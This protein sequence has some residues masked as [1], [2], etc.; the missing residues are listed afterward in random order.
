MQNQSSR[1]VLMN[2]LSAQGNC[3]SADALK[4]KFWL[5]PAFGLESKGEFRA[6]RSSTRFHLDWPAYAAGS[7]QGTRPL[8]P[9]CRLRA[10]IRFR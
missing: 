1:L 10:G 7:R 8:D 2:A 6:L 4:I 9:D 3:A 5:I